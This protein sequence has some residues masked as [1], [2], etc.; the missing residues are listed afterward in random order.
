MADFQTPM[1]NQFLKLIDCFL[2]AYFFIK[3][4]LTGSNP[5]PPGFNPGSLNQLS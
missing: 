5:D 4:E 1:R 3:W 2:S